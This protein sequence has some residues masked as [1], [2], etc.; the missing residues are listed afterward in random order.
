VVTGKW[1]DVLM[2]TPFHYMLTQY[3]GS[4]IIAYVNRNK[5]PRRC[6][7]SSGWKQKHADNSPVSGS[8]Q[9]HYI[10]TPG[11]VALQAQLPW[12]YFVQKL[13]NKDKWVP[14]FPG[15]QG[16]NSS[17]AFGKVTAWQPALWI[18]LF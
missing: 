7:G 8:C 11:S 5:M 4:D 1:A 12:G 9:W 16:L 17:A 13:Y 2:L 14:S 6:N 15:T 3:A 10:L 18:Y